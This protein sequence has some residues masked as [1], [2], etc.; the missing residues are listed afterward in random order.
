MEK[1]N[2]TGS[3]LGRELPSRDQKSRGF[4]TSRNNFNKTSQSQLIE[5]H[6]LQI[7]L[8]NLQVDE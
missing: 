2:L 5:D 7:N 6:P 3:K 8:L 1:F 4:R